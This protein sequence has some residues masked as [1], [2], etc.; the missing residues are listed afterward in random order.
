MDSLRIFWDTVGPVLVL[1]ATLASD[2]SFPVPSEWLGASELTSRARCSLRLSD[3]GALTLPAAR[4]T[5]DTAFVNNGTI[6]ANPAALLVGRFKVPQGLY[7]VQVHNTP[8]VMVT[9][10]EFAKPRYPPAGSGR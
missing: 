9:R 5:V 3:R 1:S 6:T 4:R 10:W 8:S 7:W 2:L